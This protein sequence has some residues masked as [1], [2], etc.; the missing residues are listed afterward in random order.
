MRLG[1]YVIWIFG[2]CLMIQFS[3][4]HRIVRAEG[5]SVSYV[6][7]QECKTCHEAQYQRYSKYS[8]KAKSFDRI[9][10]L[11]K[12]LTDKEF[13]HCLECHTNGYGESGGFISEVETPNLRNPGCEVCH[14]PGSTHIE[15]NQ[16][17]DISLPT[18]TEGCEKCHNSDR[19]KAFDYKPL[20]YSGAH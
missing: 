10:K 18:D 14:G 2:F 15:T 20:L 3:G 13:Q 4:I 6:G 5:K 8:K 12:G 1:K 9:L 16:V 11:K 19:I 7:S 17:E